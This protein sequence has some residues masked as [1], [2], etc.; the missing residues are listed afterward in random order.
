MIAALVAVHSSDAAT[1]T[2]SADGNWMTAGNWDALPFSGDSLFFDGLNHL[3]D[4]NNNFAAGTQF[5]DII[6]NVSAGP[7]ILA[8]NEIALGG[9]ILNSSTNLQTIG[10]GLQHSTS[11]TMDGGTGGV[12][13]DGGLKNAAAT[14]TQ[15]VTLS[16][17][18]TIADTLSVTG[19][20]R[21]LLLTSSTGSWTIKDNATSTAITTPATLNVY[22][23]GTLNFGTATSAPNFTF[24]GADSTGAQR[25]NIG[26]GTGVSTLNIANG[27]LTSQT[28][29]NVG[30]GTGGAV[31]NISGGT[32]NVGA[33]GISLA[34][35]NA[36]T[37]GTLTITGGTI[38]F[39]NT[40][41]TLF[42]ATRGIGVVNVNGGLI[43][44]RTLDLSRGIASSDGTVN[45]NGGVL[46]V[47][48]VGAA[49]ASSSVANRVAT[50][51][52]NGG[53][54]KAKASSPTF[55]KGSGD[56]QPVVTTVNVQGGGA[57]IDTDGFNDTIL[58]PLLHDATL[59]GPDGGLTKLGLGTLT[60]AGLNTYNGPTNVNNGT[61]KV[62]GGL[63]PTAAKVNANGTLQLNGTQDAAGSVTIDGGLLE[64][65]GTA[66]LVTLNTGSINP[67]LSA[68][69][70]LNVGALTLNGGSALFTLSGATSNQ[71]NATGSAVFNG[72]GITLAL[73]G[74]PLSSAT[75]NLITST[76]IS[77]IPTLNTTN[78]GRTVFSINNA[79]LANNIVQINVA[80]SSATLRWTGADLANPLQWAGDQ[81]AHNWTGAGFGDTSVFFNGDSVTFDDNNNGHY[82][83]VINGPVAPSSMTVNSSGNYTISGTGSVSGAGSFAKSGTSALTL[84]TANT[85]TGGFVL[86]SG[87]LNL[88]DASA[89]GT[90]VFTINGGTLD[91]T[92]PNPL[93]LSTNNEQ[94]WAGSFDFQGTRDLNLGTGAINLNGSLTINVLA[95]NLTAGGVIGSSANSLTKTGNGTLTL[96][97]NNTFSGGVTV[98]GGSLVVSG[99]G[100]NSALG[101]GDTTVNAGATL[102]GAVTNAFGTLP[103]HDAPANIHINGG[104]ITNLGTSS[105]AVTLPNL[106]FTGGTITSA[107]G[108]NG[109]PGGHFVFSGTGPSATVDTLPSSTTATINAPTLG[110]TTPTTF[111]VSTGSTLDGVDLLI[112]SNI[113]NNGLGRAVTKSGS[114][115]M[116]LT[117]VN[118]YTG[119]TTINEGTLQLGDGTNGS[120]TSSITVGASGTFKLNLA[121]GSTYASPINNNGTL[122]TIQSGT[123]TISTNIGGSGSLLHSGTGILNLTGTSAYFGQTTV[124]GGR[125]MVSGS[126]TGTTAV[127]VTAGARLE[128]NN[129]SV[130]AASSTTIDG[131]LQ[132][133]GMLGSVSVQNGGT[134]RA[135]AQSTLGII[136]TAGLNLTNGSHFSLRLDKI[137][138]GGQPVPGT[139]YSQVSVGQGTITLDSAIL[140]LTGNSTNVQLGDLFFLIVNGGFSPLPINGTFSGLPDQSSFTF[141]GRD[142]QISYFASYNGG[143]NPSFTGGN[144]VA[145]MVVIPEPTSLW[146]L[147]AAS[148]GLFGRRRG[149]IHVALRRA[150]PPCR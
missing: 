107:P 74:T 15:T 18:G 82:D 45:L 49:T 141:D 24:V 98:N 94:I 126:L 79:Q 13:I 134:L 113:V 143:L 52:F 150:A 118:T 112:S 91:S 92:G 69:G 117:G 139:D 27:T 111:N 80:G 36:S 146:T 50:F 86:N 87:K 67:G 3:S 109:T 144:D 23:G 83:V 148:I 21:T 81:V 77:G 5:N 2:G 132:G 108:N 66:G 72:G 121:D 60:L 63:G 133:T 51:N 149:D 131:V 17:M 43:N 90:G 54:L 19:G 116:L 119:A 35:N 136:T 120:I 20:G 38:N 95:G 128:L 97:A 29:L 42:V 68:V 59:P 122:Q 46:A 16:G 11:F 137:F 6:F 14:G 125:L 110:I 65:T 56:L 140:D 7:F 70:V 8:G 4:N 130:N 28:R 71:I 85:H 145:L 75:Y 103:G 22:N 31:L 138:A 44:I 9:N 88:N 37:T 104:T 78:I 142:Y 57:I 89:L 115:S 127:S 101:S 12:T 34:D 41:T 147:A 58:D 93:A 102:V 53:T 106:T 129:G 99:T 76:S 26:N 135:G 105:Y 10:L 62:S 39:T 123:T 47:E 64:G 73:G 48:R 61:M 96:S 114:G 55:F 30:N 40:A 1:W 33:T 100:G 84:S 25:N 32:L 124:S